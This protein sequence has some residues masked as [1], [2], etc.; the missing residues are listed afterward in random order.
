MLYIKYG[1]FRNLYLDRL[2]AIG[3]KENIDPCRADHNLSDL[4]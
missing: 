3:C 1:L 2:I 4:Q